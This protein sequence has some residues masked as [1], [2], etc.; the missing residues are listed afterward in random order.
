MSNIFSAVCTVGRDSEVRYLPP[1]G[2]AVLNVTLAN[3]CGYVD[4][5][6]T[7][8]IRGVLWGK[9]AEGKIADYL[10][11]GQ[12]VFISGEL[13]TNEY[14]KNNGEKGFMLEVNISVI[15]LI[16]KKEDKEPPTQQPNRTPPTES[17]KYEQPDDDIP[18]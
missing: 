5:K 9:R 6:K 18:F 16:G 12:Q 4:N 3:N 2:Q 13:T 8:W 1:S 17:Y 11:K 10:K 15:D 7:N 14:T